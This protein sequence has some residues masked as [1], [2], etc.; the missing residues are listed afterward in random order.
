MF[1]I[2]CLS[3]FLAIFSF[4]IFAK[5]R[6]LSDC[7]SNSYNIGKPRVGCVRSWVFHTE[8]YDWDKNITLFQEIL[9]KPVEG[10][11]LD[12]KTVVAEVALNLVIL[13]SRY[14]L[15]QLAVVGRREKDV[16]LDGYHH[17]GRCD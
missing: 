15:H 16:A 12:K 5:L 6:F 8:V 1:S 17:C 13:T 3:V 10:L 2:D 9:Y 14:K 11:V 7:T 4:D